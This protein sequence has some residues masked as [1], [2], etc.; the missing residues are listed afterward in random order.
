[1]QKKFLGIFDKKIYLNL[2]IFT[3]YL[4][5]MFCRNDVFHGTNFDLKSFH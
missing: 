3:C 5:P 1:M 2:K 4:S